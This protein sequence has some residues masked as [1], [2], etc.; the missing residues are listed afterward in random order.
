M[1]DLRRRIAGLNVIAELLYLD[2]KKCP[3][4]SR[5]LYPW[6]SRLS[7]R[8]GP[9]APRASRRSWLMR[10]PAREIGRS[11]PGAPIAGGRRL[12]LVNGSLELADARHRG[13]EYRRRTRP[14][15]VRTSDRAWASASAAGAASGLDV[16]TLSAFDAQRW[17]WPTDPLNEAT[18]V[19]PSAY[20]SWTNAKAAAR[21]GQREHR[22]HQ[23]I[24]QAIRRWRARSKRVCISQH[25][26]ANAALHLSEPGRPGAAASSLGGTPG[27]R[28]PRPR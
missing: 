1:G 8:H 27:P 22:H 20:L 17:W 28:S 4:P 24:T 26:A 11:G 16:R 13:R 5:E 14:S 21:R 19:F 18:S 15:S 6:G 9:A 12:E 7:G 25:H 10:S 3:R 23:K 2:L